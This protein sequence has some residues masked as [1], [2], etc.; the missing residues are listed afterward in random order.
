M[1]SLAKELNRPLVVELNAPLSDE[2]T[3]YRAS[4][5]GDLAR[6]AEQKLLCNADVVL[7]VSKT[8]REYAVSMGANANNVHVV[9]NA[10]NS[11]LFFP[12]PKNT[13]LLNELRLAGGPVIGFVGGLRPWHGAASLINLTAKLALSFPNIKLV[14]VGDGPLKAELERQ[15]DLNNLHNN[16]LFAG[17][18]KHSQVPDLIRL[19]DIALAPYPK[20]DHAFYFSPLKIFEYMGCG[21]PVVASRT[22]QI[23]EVIEHEYNGMLYES[24]NDNELLAVCTKLLNDKEMATTVARNAAATIG[25]SYTWTKNAQ[26]VIDIVNGLKA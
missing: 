9:P 10:V 23:E 11:A 2:H 26:R 3:I 16:V 19:F 22:G 12:S 14:I 5:L 24:G 13:T 8:L 25:N 20:A 4:G 21:V 7:T 15:I 1:L 18:C 17:T 6:K